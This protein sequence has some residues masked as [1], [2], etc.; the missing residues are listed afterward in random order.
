[1]L[2]KANYKPKKWNGIT[3]ERGQLVLTHSDIQELLHWKVGFRKMTYSEDSVKKAM[4]TLRTLSM[5]ALTKARTYTL[6]TICNYEYYQDIFNYEGTRESTDESTMKAPIKHVG[7]TTT[8][9]YKDNKEEKKKE[10]IYP[11]DDFWNDY[12]KKVDK[13]K[14]EPKWKKLSDSDKSAIKT[15]IP[16]YKLEQPDKKFRKNPEAY[17]NARAWENEILDKVG[18]TANQMTDGRPA[19]KSLNI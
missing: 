12:D 14:V 11:F 5:I 13:P 19:I 6:I 10:D 18:K 8:K 7:A 3:I 15:H 17:L 4:K 9:E 2:R 1:M 16:K